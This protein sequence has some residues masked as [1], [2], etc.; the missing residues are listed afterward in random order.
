M[1]SPTTNSFAPRTPSVRVHGVA[2]PGSQ[3]SQGILLSS[4]PLVLEQGGS[5]SV[6]SS[7]NQPCCYFLIILEFISVVSECKFLLNAERMKSRNAFDYHCKLFIT[8]EPE[9]SCQVN[10]FLQFVSHLL[11]IQNAFPH[12]KKEVQNR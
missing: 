7:T 12:I 4:C 11:L 2:C 9:V 3:E 8:S 10:I 6:C 5:S 1:N